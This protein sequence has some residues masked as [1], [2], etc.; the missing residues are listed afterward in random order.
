MSL[1]RDALLAEEAMITVYPYSIQRMNKSKRLN[2]SIIERFR[3]VFPP[4]L[5][6]CSLNTISIHTW[7]Q[8]N[9]PHS[10]R[11]PVQV[12]QSIHGALK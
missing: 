1:G 2:Q 3:K 10:W 11:S 7:I 8:N 5:Q 12:F 4:E 9:A 6:R